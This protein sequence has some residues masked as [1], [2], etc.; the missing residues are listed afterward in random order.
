MVA[1]HALTAGS[2]LSTEDDSIIARLV[3]S[4]AVSGWTQVAHSQLS[5][6][7]RQLEIL[8]AVAR[9]LMANDEDLSEAAIVLEYR[10]PRREKRIDAAI[11]LRSTVIVIEFKVGAT[12][13]G[14]ED[15]DQVLDYALDIAYYHDQSRGRRIVP[16]LCPTKL[17]VTS[18]KAHGEGVLIDDLILCGESELPDLVLSLARTESK[19]EPLIATQSWVL[20][21]YKPIPGIVDAAVRLFSQHEVEDVNSALAEVDTIRET[22]RLVESIIK[23]A[24]VGGSK[25]LCLLTGVPGAGKTLTGLQ[26]AHLEEL[27]RSEWLTVFMSGNGPL[28]KVLR[29]ALA[30]DYAKREQVT[31]LKSKIHAETLLHNVHA[32]LAESLKSSAAPAERVIIFDEAQR[33][34]DKEKM[35]KMA[36]KARRNGYSSVEEQGGNSAEIQSE[37]WQLLST[38]DRH[39]TGAVL[40]ALCGNGQ[41]IHDGEAGVAEWVAARDASFRDWQLVCSPIAAELANL[42]GR[43]DVL[44]EEGLHLAVPLRSHR[45]YSHAHW[46]DAVLGGDA[47]RASKFVDQNELPILITRELER[48]REWLWRT[49]VGTRRCGLLASSGGTRLRPYGVEVSSDFRGGI[50]YTHWFTKDRNDL[51]SSHFL[52]V[53]ATE[54]ECQGLELDRVGLC[55]SWDLA[56]S[57]GRLLPR[58]F[59]GTSWHDVRGKRERDF[60]LNKYRVLLTR[61]REGMVIWVPKGRAADATRSPDEADEIATYLIACGARSLDSSGKGG[62]MSTELLVREGSSAGAGAL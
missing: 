4:D 29:S 56:L 54:F 7:R 28:I 33:A 45:A 59:K 22:I 17:A 58:A 16:V 13:A 25:V 19:N 50:D 23:R 3:Q 48:A 1:Y 47:D 31:Q 39:E 49:T 5:A 21:A 37:P 20:S 44:I 11:L 55:W 34:W 36:A 62:G 32:Y 24:Q 41:E 35:T 51:R 10:V 52:E 30:A 15:R 38:L 6:W 57:G 12:H 53:P 18:T 8:R 14:A 9:H 26:V 43:S 60:I 42:E 40:V 27:T 46:V 2:L 61:A